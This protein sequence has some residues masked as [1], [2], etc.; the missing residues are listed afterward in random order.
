MSG[1]LRRIFFFPQT[2]AFSALRTFFMKKKRADKQE[3]NNF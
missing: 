3:D 2:A 1:E